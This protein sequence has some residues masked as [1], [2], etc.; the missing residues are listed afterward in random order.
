MG[1]GISFVDGDGM[2]N[3]ITGIENNTWLNDIATIGDPA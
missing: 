3:T 2:G 1:K